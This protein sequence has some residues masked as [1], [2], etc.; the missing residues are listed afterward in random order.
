[1]NTVT[2][3][4]RSSRA[5]ILTFTINTLYQVNGINRITC[6]GTSD[7]IFSISNSTNKCTAKN[8]VVFTDVA[9]VKISNTIVFFYSW[10]LEKGRVSA[11]H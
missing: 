9:R 7:L 11:T 5:N 3:F 1:M 4:K 8:H 6:K 10:E 2:L